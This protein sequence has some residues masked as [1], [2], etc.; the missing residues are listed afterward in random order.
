MATTLP[1]PPLRETM[2]S[3]NGFITQIWLKWFTQL[4]KRVLG[5]AGTVT[6]TPGA[7]ST[8]V[9][10][11]AC[12]TSSIILMTPATAAAVTTDISSLYVVS[13]NGSFTV[14]HANSATTGRVFNYLVQV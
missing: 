5:F 1:P 13:G 6:L 8:V 3:D 7:A 4:Y 9:T 11:P 2:Q 10:L 14:T 12:T